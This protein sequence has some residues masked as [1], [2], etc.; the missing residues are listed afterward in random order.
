MSRRVSVCVCVCVEKK[1]K[2]A[3]NSSLQWDGG[4]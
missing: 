3:V 4:L 2:R 1:K